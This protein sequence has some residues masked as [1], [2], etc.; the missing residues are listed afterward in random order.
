[1][2][3]TTGLGPVSAVTETPVRTLRETVGDRVADA[4][5]IVPAAAVMVITVVGQANE[6]VPVSAWVLYADRVTGVLSLLALWWRR[7]YPVV[8]GIA[9]AVASSF[10]ETT[11]A[12]AIVALFTVAVH[13][14]ARVT[15]AVCA[16]SL[17]AL[18]GYQLRWPEAAVPP[19][20]VFVIIGLGH[21]ATVAAG[22]SVRSRRALVASLRER[23]AAAEVEAQLRAEHA[24]REAREALAR[25]MHDVLGHRLSLLSV[26]AG[27]L[28]YHRGASPQDRARAAEV[29][30]ESA[31]RAL[32]DLREVIGVLRA[33]VGEPPPGAED[34]PEL[35][36]EARRAGTPVELRDEA[37]VTTGGPSLPGTHGHTLYRLVQ[38]ALTNVRKHAAG[39]L[40][41]IRITGRPGDHV[42]AEVVNAPP[43]GP[44]SHPGGSGAGLRGL[45]ERA[46]LVTGQL[47]HGPTDSGGWRVG[48]RL[49]WPS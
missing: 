38:E 25:E 34:V 3:H 18:S 29:V 41:V 31:H 23:V 9:L 2:G 40:V 24:E 45:R 22:L 13:R 12:A 17:A 30:R 8:V 14:P 26:H 48:L 37:G 20:T 36:D 49:P 44:P 10:S 42:T 6:P 19:L 47:D 21:L 35:V 46:R 16:T 15:A 32:Q 27:A 33:P 43:A 5:L 7:R 1:M 4:A 28:T 11:A 39:A